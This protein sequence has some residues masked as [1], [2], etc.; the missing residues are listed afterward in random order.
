MR[1]IP[2]LV[3]AMQRLGTQPAESRSPSPSS[4]PQKNRDSASMI[5][6]ER[7]ASAFGYAARAHAAQLRKGS[8]V[9]YIS[10]PLAVSALVLEYGGDEDQAIAALLHDVIEDGGAAHASP[11]NQYFG[12]RVLRIVLDCTDALGAQK[13]EW[14]PRKQRYLEHLAGVAPDSLLVNA[15]DKLH[16]A[17]CILR[18]LQQ[19]GDAAFERFS[20][21][22]EPVLWYYRKLSELFSRREALPAAAL[23]EVVA[24]I[25]ALAG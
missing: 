13:P 2:T 11:I 23:R 10:H 22:R 25:E 12:E 16:N 21:G 19:Y 20:A 4:R 7:F 6:S 17:R 5:S 9:P 18:D 1:R 3:A 24:G 14:L 8:T 15:C